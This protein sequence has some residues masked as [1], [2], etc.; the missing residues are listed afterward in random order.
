[1][2]RNRVWHGGSLEHPVVIVINC[3]FIMT[4]KDSS[5]R[6]CE[7]LVDEADSWITVASRVLLHTACAQA[8][9]T[10]FLSVYLSVFILH[11][12][13]AEIFPVLM[14]KYNCFALTADFSKSTCLK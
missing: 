8:R 7:G 14:L 12:K 2:L 13:S 10:P 5:I 11:N 6:F 9:Y 1:M 3:V 4:A